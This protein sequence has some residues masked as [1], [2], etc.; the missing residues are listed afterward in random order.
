[1][2]YETNSGNITLSPRGTLYRPILNTGPKIPVSS[3]YSRQVFKT[4]SAEF[5]LDTTAVRSRSG[6]EYVRHTADTSVAAG[7]G[8]LGPASVFAPALALPVA[9]VGIGY[10][11]YKAGEALKLW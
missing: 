11:I 3:P 10:G 6:T 2:I 1:M 8:V 4:P 5:G 7:L 9:T